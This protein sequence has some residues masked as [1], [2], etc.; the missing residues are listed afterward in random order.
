MLNGY[1]TTIHLLAGGLGG[2]LTA[3]LATP[4]DTIKVRMQTKIYV[5]AADPFP[6]L[7]RVCKAT[8][9]EGGW[10]GLWRGAT[11]RFASNAPAGAIMF[12]VYESGYRWFER[13]LY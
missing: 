6:S 5:T 1:T 11:Y 2:G 8:L 10:Q 4:F 13:K 7:L 12:A 3:V 9:Q